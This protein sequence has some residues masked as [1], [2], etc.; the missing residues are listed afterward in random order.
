[1]EERGELLRNQVLAPG[2]ATMRPEQSL[3][4]HSKPDDAASIGLNVPNR[5]M[6][7][8]IQSQSIPVGVNLNRYSVYHD[9]S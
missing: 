3:S 9:Y 6:N 8:P 2:I 5:M 4:L 7:G 1:M